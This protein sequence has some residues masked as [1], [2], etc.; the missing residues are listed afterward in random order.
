MQKSINSGS[1]II[2]NHI[3]FVPVKN[4]S[5]NLGTKCLKSI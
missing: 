1:V 2:T 4:V 3:H 5:N